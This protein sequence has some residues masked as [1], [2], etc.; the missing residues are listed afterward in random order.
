MCDIL[1]SIAYT[2]PY[3]RILTILFKR[4]HKCIYPEDKEE[5]GGNTFYGRTRRASAAKYMTLE[6]SVWKFYTGI[7]YFCTSSKNVDQMLSNLTID[8]KAEILKDAVIMGGAFADDDL[9]ALVKESVEKGIIGGAPSFLLKWLRTFATSEKEVVNT[10][11]HLFSLISHKERLAVMN[12]L[13][14]HEFY[15]EE[16]H[17]AMFHMTQGVVINDE[18]FDFLKNNLDNELGKALASSFLEIETSC[19]MQANLPYELRLLCERLLS[20]MPLHQL[21]DVLI[22]R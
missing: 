5:E 21:Q 10:F 7:P 17:E 3:G 8:Q 15:N 13:W 18:M 6:G 2:S 12:E 16:T 9:R 4:F 19:G 1:Q 14:V 22:G 20:D 11:V